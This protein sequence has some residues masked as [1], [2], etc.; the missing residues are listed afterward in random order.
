MGIV[1]R[2]KLKS[3]YPR[4]KSFPATPFKVRSPINKGRR[5]KRPNNILL[6]GEAS[7][8]GCRL[9]A[10]AA[11]SPSGGARSGLSQKQHK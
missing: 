2:D 9:L 8:V 7:F 4:K 6:L 3:F 1:S 10:A 11:K 5:F